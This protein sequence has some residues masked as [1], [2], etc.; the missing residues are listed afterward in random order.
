MD[1][2][3]AQ[4][5]YD[6]YLTNFKEEMERHHFGKVALM[7]NCEIVNIYNDE[8]DAYSIGCDQYGLGN[9]SLVN[10]GKRPAHLGMRLTALT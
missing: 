2:N 6:A 4:A 3:Q 7:H 10:I 1:S 9:F 8:G 5:N